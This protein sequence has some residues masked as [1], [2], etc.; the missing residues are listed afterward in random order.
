MALDI[1]HETVRHAL[2]A[3]GWTIT[4]D[5]LVIPFGDTTLYVDF[6]AERLIAAEKA[7]HKIA[8]EVKSFL[9][10]SLVRDLENALGQYLLYQSVLLRRDADRVLY[11]AVPRN[12][13]EGILSSELGRAAV[14][15][16]QL[17]LIVFDPDKEQIAKW[18][19]PPATAKS[20]RM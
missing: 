1:F 11:L 14:E 17:R 12:V 19:E 18:I 3:D 10:R 9:S 8:V 13:E 2:V 20:S 5:P 4:H 6:G 7:G 16:Y 15:D